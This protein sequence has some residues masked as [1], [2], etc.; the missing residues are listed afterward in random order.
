MPLS[1]SQGDEPVPGYRL[2]E[3]LGSGGFGAVWKVDGPGGV[4]AALKIIN[5]Q[6]N[7]AHR[8]LRAFQRVKLIRHPN[9]VPIAGMWLKDDAGSF[10]EQ[11]ERE[12]LVMNQAEPGSGPAPPV[13]TTQGQ[14]A[15]LLLAMGLGDRNLYDRLLQT[16][17]SF[18][19][20]VPPHE[21]LHYMEDAARAI[22]FLNSPA[23][24]LGFGLVAIHHCD[25]K[26]QNMVIVGG[27]VQLC[28][29]G[30]AT[31]LGCDIGAG[32]IAVTPAYAAP[33]L[34]RRLG[35][36]RTTD[37]YSLAVSYYELR[38]G[39]L[40]FD[41]DSFEEV[42]A[43]QLEGRLNLSQLST[44]ERLV[45]E[46]ATAL[47]PAE[48]FSSATEMVVS[49]RQSVGIESR[50]WAVHAVIRTESQAVHGAI[51]HARQSA[52]SS[53]TVRPTPR[54]NN[55]SR[56]SSSRFDTTADGAGG[57]PVQ[58]GSGAF[59]I[60]LVLFGFVAFGLAILHVSEAGLAFKLAVSLAIVGGAIFVGLLSK[61][62]RLSSPPRLAGTS[63]DA[64]REGSTTSQGSRR[65][66]NLDDFLRDTIHRSS[67]QIPCGILYRSSAA[68]IEVHDES[69]IVA[70][71][72]ADC[73]IRIS[74]AGVPAR[75][76]LISVKEGALCMRRLQGAGPAVSVNQHE[77]DQ[78]E[79]K[80]EDEITISNTKVR[81]RIPWIHWQRVIEKQ[82]RADLSVSPDTLDPI[83]TKYRE[84][85]ISRFVEECTAYAVA[86]VSDCSIQL[87]NRDSIEC[88]RQSAELLD[89]AVDASRSAEAVEKALRHFLGVTGMEL[90]PHS[91]AKLDFAVHAMARLTGHSWSQLP[92]GDQLPVVFW[93]TQGGSEQI[94]EKLHDLMSNDFARKYSLVLAVILRDDVDMIRLRRRVREH[95]QLVQGYNAVILHRRDLED[96]L[97]G[98]PAAERL[99]HKVLEQA[100]L[101]VLSPFVVGGPVPKGMFF[102]RENEITLV[103]Q[104]V[105]HDRGSFCIPG[106]RRIGK[107]SLLNRVGEILLGH[108][109]TVV[110]LDLSIVDSYEAFAFLLDAG[111]FDKS[112]AGTSLEQIIR[113][114]IEKDRRGT[115]RSFAVLLLDEVDQLLRF[116]MSRGD[117]FARVLR[118]LSASAHSKFVLVGEEIL[119]R[120]LH[121]ANCPLY[122]FARTVRLSMLD[123]KSAHELLLR[124]LERLRVCW[125]CSPAVRQRLF[126]VTHC[127]PNVLQVIGEILISQLNEADT[128]TITNAMIE[129]VTCNERLR[130]YA[131][132]TLWGR[133]STLGRLMLLAASDAPFLPQNVEEELARAGIESD[134]H[135]MKDA[136]VMLDLY[137][138]VERAEGGYKRSLDP[139]R[140]WGSEYTE[141][142][143][144]ELVA[145]FKADLSHV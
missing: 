144:G 14:P 38:T 51:A 145:E 97:A 17:R 43:A 129:S 49:L 93:T 6:A 64:N 67:L 35:P 131:W 141:R 68:P 84:A 3:L 37:Q 140:V 90:V 133:V 69:M 128:R 88:L 78:F 125:E 12:Q 23:H 76:V 9:L 127:H 115:G 70:G 54:Y 94:V 16:Q 130:D 73:A 21:L 52:D 47:D 80:D 99:R 139:V 31:V 65:T 124:P 8:E 106:G 104:G 118:T 105:L 25:I 110:Y 41:S 59:F 36:R 89:G 66:L 58:R 134:N 42:V 79:L 30:L 82:L 114:R 61:I 87:A 135:A 11:E 46:R 5:L 137:G 119:F 57:S 10:I 7:Q 98:Q 18:P 60:Y 39:S 56:D 136:M 32:P 24:D 28:D 4:P 111:S 33:E 72:D 126:E 77:V 13:A 15:Q 45:I 2:L 100:N 95:L 81:V 62:Y 138:L 143:R 86:Q 34:I 112:Q 108:G 107:S 75:H 74:A 117:V 26:P 109:A 53:S 48:R 55:G 22:D 85:A 96:I 132:D 113:A 91:I 142:R 29:F 122:N 120:A 71:S 44:A 1:Y 116:D 19:R 121:N 40:P 63:D 101:S 50:S 103:T 123:E 92:I 102:G 83:P 20:G 27:A